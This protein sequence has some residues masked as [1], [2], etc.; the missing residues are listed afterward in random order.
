MAESEKINELSGKYLGETFGG[1]F[2]L[3]EL[4]T[5]RNEKVLEQ[6]K[7]EK[8]LKNESETLT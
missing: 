7:K 6:I 2:A 1:L 8:T 5:F 3:L 4:E